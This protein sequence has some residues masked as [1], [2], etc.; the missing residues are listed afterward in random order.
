MFKRRSGKTVGVA[1]ALTLAFVACGDDPVDVGPNLLGPNPRDVEFVAS[2]GI[3]L[4]DM[5]ETTSGLFYRDDVVGAG[6]DIAAAGDAA[7]VGYVLWLVDGTSLGSG[8]FPFVLGTIG[9]GG[10]IAGF[11]EGVTGMR[12]GGERTLVIPAPLAYGSGGTP[13]IPGDAVLVY[14]LA[15]TALD[16]AQP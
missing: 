4:A 1:V 7:T 12:V 9:S 8:V 15:L 3:D 6:D 10:A 5:V 16:K 11:D 2:L 13:G 14:E